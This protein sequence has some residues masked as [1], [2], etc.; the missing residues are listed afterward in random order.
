[1]SAPARFRYRWVAPGD[2][3]GF[4]A[5]SIDNLALLAGMSGIL[6]GVF[7]MPPEMVLGQM[8]PGTAF[9]VLVGDL[10]YAGLAWRLAHR[11]ERSDV[12]AMPLGI[13][14][15]SMFALCVGVIGPTFLATH[16]AQLTWAVGMAVLFL[17]G[18]VKFI[19]AFF[20]QFIRRT[21][22]RTALLGALSAVALALIVFFPFRKIF[23]EPVG[24]IVALGVVLLTLVGRVRLPFGL[25]AM[26]VSVLAGLGAIALARL[27]GYTGAALAVV[28][29]PFALH[30]PWP[31]WALFAGLHLAWPLLPLAIPIALATIVGG[32]DNTESAAL[33]G[34]RYATRSILLVEAISTLAQ[35][36]CGGV[37]QTTPYIGHP[38]YKAMG[39]RAGYVIA[40]GLF[41]GV[42]AATGVVGTLITLLPESVVV[43]ILIFIGLEMSVQT[44]RA[45]E[46]R[47]LYAIG[48]ALIP[49]LAYASA[50]QLAGLMGEAHVDPG[51]FSGAF[52]HD[53]EALTMLGNGF[54]ISAMVWA[55]WI[56]WIIDARF[57]RAALIA[58][59]AGL[60]TLCGAIHSPFPDGHMFW[61]EAAT[62]QAVYALAGAYGL[63][64]LT[65]VA[66]HYLGLRTGEV[67]SA[68]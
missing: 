14:T 60:L 40:A 23:A 17:M 68:P 61:P 50:I 55:S 45:T 53:L 13:D 52:R 25:P 48:V 57:W 67:E 27:L 21:L 4:F 62:P 51:V 6:V 35:A 37:V 42:G 44:V 20:G 12:C 26:L 7:H 66:A 28:S 46:T 54:I 9:G 32:I 22:P 39:C 65:C 1:M 47:H 18:S 29:P 15:P 56:V 10:L 31:T 11:E 49:V 33:A 5:L 43:P 24:G 30:W 2:L 64:A 38:A 58:L 59:L 41:I 34:D 36:F 16:D 63:L 3:N 8:I 19:A